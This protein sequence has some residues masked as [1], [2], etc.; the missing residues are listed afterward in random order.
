[1]KLAQFDYEL[2]KELIASYLISPRDHSKLMLIDKQKNKI[3][4]YHFLDLHDLLNK[5]DVLVFNKTKVFPARLI[6]RR[7]SQNMNEV[8]ANIEILLHK[9]INNNIWEA[10]YKG[11]LKANDRISFGKFKAELIEKTENIVK[12]RF[13]TDRNIFGLLQ[14]YGHTPIPPYIKTV[15]DENY[16]RKSY[17]TVYA[18]EIGSVAA[19]T[20]GFHFTK[21]LLQKLKAKGVQM[22]YLTLHV[23]LGTFEPI[24]EDDINHHKL[25]S[26]YFVLNS[27]T[28][29]RLNKAKLMNRNIVSVGT[30]TTRVLET[31][32]KFNKKYKSYLL[33]PRT[34][35]T[36][37]FIYPPYKFIFVD[38][39]ITNF[40]LPKS[41]LLTLVSAFVSFPNTKDGFTDFNLSLM[42]K[43][44]RQAIRRMYRFYSF[45]DSCLIR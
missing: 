21:S 43:A 38:C 26:E 10:V 14:K 20:A 45:G 42:G 2:P 29:S 12:I 22:E 33:E 41:T 13:L 37:I 16:L 23:G 32:A 7:L 30:T 1:M 36:N 15:A 40:H 3:G 25:H 5:N 9:K 4:H 24:R 17:Q 27:R 39:L 28:A 44:Y 8:G 18:K 31:C 35:Y 6:G 34:G 19:P 11:H